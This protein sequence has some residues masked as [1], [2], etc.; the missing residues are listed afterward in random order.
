MI[1][2][3]LRFRYVCINIKKRGEGGAS[4]VQVLVPH[5]FA[6]LTEIVNG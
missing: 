6:F 5:G 4:F 3:S 2:F 1:F